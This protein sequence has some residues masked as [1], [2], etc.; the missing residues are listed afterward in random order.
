MKIHSSGSGIPPGNVEIFDRSVW[1]KEKKQ[2][3][4]VSLESSKILNCGCPRSCNHAAL[5]K[6]MTGF[7]FSC[8]ARI[9][10]LMTKYNNSQTEACHEA[11]KNNMCGSE[12]NPFQCLIN[13][14]I[15]AK[16]QAF[17]QEHPISSNA[18]TCGCQRTCDTIALLKR[19]P[20][21]QFSCEKRID[22]LMSRYG[23]NEIDACSGAVESEFC[24]KECDPVHCREGEDEST[25]SME[26]PKGHLGRLKVMIIA[27]VPRDE[28]HA[29]AL[30]TELECLTGGMD[31]IILSAPDWSSNLTEHIA[32]EAT[33]KLA[34]AVTTRYYKK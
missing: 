10:H 14:E 5:A 18:F 16:N 22:F 8:Q 30:W 26:I 19:A 3:R 11:V 34:I 28:K 25:E 4:A 13:G 6:R 29:V 1:H 9:K 2:S 12:C 31:L 21:K 27:T 24:G 23:K 7:Q 33:K 32:R 15:D 20:G 17:L